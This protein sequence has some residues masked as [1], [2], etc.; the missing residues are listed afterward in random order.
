M[1]MCLVSLPTAMSQESEILGRRAGYKRKGHATTDETATKPPS[2]MPVPVYLDFGKNVV[3]QISKDA[4]ETR[5]RV[6]HNP[7]SIRKH[8]HVRQTVR[9]VRSLLLIRFTGV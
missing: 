7:L 6:L 5:F 1:S 4:I 2:K 3:R 8:Q 9:G